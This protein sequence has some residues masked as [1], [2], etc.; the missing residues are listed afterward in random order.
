MVRKFF[1]FLQAIL[2]FEL[3]YA[4][5]NEDDF[6]IFSYDTTIEIFKHY[7]SFDYHKAYQLLDAWSKAY[8]V[9]PEDSKANLIMFAMD[10]AYD[11]SRY[12]AFTGNT[13][14]AIENL[15]LAISY[16]FRNYY[17]LK[18]EVAFKNFYSNQDFLKIVEYLKSI[19]DNLTILHS[20]PNYSEASYNMPDFTYQ[21]SNDKN[22]QYL[23]N[24]YKLDSIAGNGNEETK[25]INLMRWVHNTV[26][27]DG[28][29]ISPQNQNALSF[30]KQG[31]KEKLSLNCHAMAILANDVYLSMGIPSR[32]VMCFPKDSVDWEHHVINA[33]YS[34]MNNKWLYIDP[35]NA[36]Y[37][38]DSNGEMLGI[39]EV[40]EHL[41]NR[42]T[43]ILNP[44]ANWNQTLTRTESEYLWNYMAKNMYWFECP[45]NSEFDYET[46]K[47]FTTKTYIRLT[48][49][50][51]SNSNHLKNNTYYTNNEAEFW[52]APKQPLSNNY[53]NASQ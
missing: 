27:H 46:P 28:F 4:Q 26:R 30:L 12:Y 44:D 47:E 20:S 6:R 42:K 10:N 1:F 37:V 50:G 33:V 35:T 23:K 2:L 38:M 19:G 21:F 36:A 11:Y 13:E 41:I 5:I 22:L 52:A 3:A 29:K 16:G 43:L 24:T 7:S 18:A 51:Y 14:A 17:K 32:Y 40:R 15:N 53:H 45:L 25:I 8:A 49:Y 48:P 39:N 34:K 9:L 31:A